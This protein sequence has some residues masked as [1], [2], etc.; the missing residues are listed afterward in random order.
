MQDQ[1]KTFITTT[2]TVIQRLENLKDIPT[3][4]L[5]QKII[6]SFDGYNVDGVEDLVGFDKWCD[7]FKNG[8]Y[9]LNIKANHEDA[10]EFTIYI[11]TKDNLSSVVNVL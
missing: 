2:K 11:N 5:K 4:K 1:V 6:D 10:Y 8:E 9:Q 7:Y 3:D